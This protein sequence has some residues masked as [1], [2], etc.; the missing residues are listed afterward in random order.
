[1]AKGKKIRTRGKIRLSRYFKRYAEGEKVSVV[2]E[3]SVK[4]A[5]PERLQGRTG[6]VD[7]KRGRF[8]VVRIKDM[9]KEK[10]YVI[11]PI[12]LKTINS[13]GRN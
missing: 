13:G 12:H 9:N 7:G 6:V 3:A 5:F 1:M 4:A 8:Y 11:E 10:K 2:R